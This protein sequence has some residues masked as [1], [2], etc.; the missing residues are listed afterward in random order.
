[1]CI[2]LLLL[3]KILVKKKKEKNKKKETV[4]G[5][6]AFFAQRGNSGK[7]QALLRQFLLTLIIKF[8][9]HLFYH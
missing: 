8:N 3:F 5:L 2:N 9:I 7:C 6:I 4:P 1:M